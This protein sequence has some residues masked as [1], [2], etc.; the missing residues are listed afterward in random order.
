MARNQ[1]RHAHIARALDGEVAMEPTGGRYLSMT[2]SNRELRIHQCHE[3][4]IAFPLT[5][6]TPPTISGSS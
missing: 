1:R 5:L 4:F 3:N 2:A 6:S